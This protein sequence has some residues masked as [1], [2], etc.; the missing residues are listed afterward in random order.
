MEHNV[1][2]LFAFHVN[3]VLFQNNIQMKCLLTLNSART[4]NKQNEKHFSFPLEFE[5]MQR[6]TDGGDEWC[7]ISSDFLISRAFKFTLIPSRPSASIRILNS[8]LAG[9][10]GL[11]SKCVGGSRWDTRRDEWLS[12][13]LR[14]WE[15]FPEAFWILPQLRQRHSLRFD[16]EVKRRPENW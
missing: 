2:I 9:L 6:R 8:P 4:A 5:F 15:Q 11:I 13:A 12:Q 1:H 16:T 10:A 14:S 7:W 3:G